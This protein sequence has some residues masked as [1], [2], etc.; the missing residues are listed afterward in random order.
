MQ[1]GVPVM[2]VRYHG[3]I[4]DFVMLNAITDTP[5][6]WEAIDQASHMPKKKILSDR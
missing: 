6:A 4:Y 1:A 3:T 2:G 5:D